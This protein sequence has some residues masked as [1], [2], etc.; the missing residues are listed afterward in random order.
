[1]TK[2]GSQMVWL[3]SPADVVRCA[4]K[5]RPDSHKGE[6]GVAL[7]VGGCNELVGAPALGAQAALASLRTGID[8]VR[9]MAPEKVAWV[10]NSFSPD[11]I[12]LKLR[13]SHLGERHV[14]EV[15]AE[16][17]KADAV[18]IGP[19][20]GLDP[21]TRSFV[22]RVLP[23]IRKPLI[24]DADALKAAKGLKFKGPALITP[25]A[26]EF[27]AFTGKK[28][29]KELSKQIKAVEAAAKKHRCVVLLKGRFDVV[30]D[31]KT[32]KV[33][34]TG[35]AGMT[36]GGTG[37]VL[38]GICLGLAASKNGLLDVAC[39]AAY[40]NGRAG[41]ILHAVKGYTFIASDF[42]IVIPRLLK[43]WGFK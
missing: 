36:V 10:I 22:R 29:P 27:E 26:K 15:L 40:L 31:G 38:A 25:H 41:D 24:V 1:M 5:R 4:R 37:D 23:K 2:P 9:V 18:L 3:C 16:A 6:N 30:S 11:L 43:K 19:G 28:L 17:A 33:N 35:N 34:K 14:R 20:M 13:G 42:L 21:E 32:T 39:A 8:L 7:V 12:T